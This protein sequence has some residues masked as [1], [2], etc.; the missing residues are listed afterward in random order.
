MEDTL[1]VNGLKRLGD[2][3][4][5]RQSAANRPRFAGRHPG[6]QGRAGHILHDQV[7]PARNLATVVDGDHVGMAQRAHDARF[8]LKGR[9]RCF[10]RRQGAQPLDG[11]GARQAE[12]GGPVDLAH[13]AFADLFMDLVPRDRR[14]RFRPGRGLH[15][16]HAEFPRGEGSVQR[17]TGRPIRVASLYSVNESES[18]ISSSGQTIS[19]CETRPD[20]PSKWM[21]Y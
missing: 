13:A 16:H 11:D 5:N 7:L 14:R 17:G 1:L 2:G 20:V 19:V 18:P 3:F 15:L 4:E 8:A 21:N 6:P 9:R 12:L 10:A